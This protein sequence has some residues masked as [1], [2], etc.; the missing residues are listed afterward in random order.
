MTLTVVLGLVL[1]LGVVLIVSSFAWPATGGARARSRSAGGFLRQRLARAGLPSVSL[2]AVG[3]VSVV[4]GLAIAALS[5]ALV[6]VM[7]ISL[8][9]G[10]GALALPLAMIQWRVRSRRRAAR[11]LWPD[12][13]DHLV[14]AVRSGLALPDSVVTL[15]HTGPA[16]TRDA[17]SEF[18][19]DY[20]ATGNFGL[21]LDA[22]KDR[23]ADPVADRILETLRMSREVG[24]SELTTVLRNLSSYLRQ[25]AAIR[26]EVE[27]RQ[28][29]VVNA[30]RLG[31]A[32]PWVI[33][34][35][36]ATRP[37]AAA[38]YNTA[39]GALLIVGGLFVTVIA[40]RLMLA[41]GRFPEERRW[42]A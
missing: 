16:P 34:V 3:V 25:E 8:I 36:L 10:A 41:L 15:A 28:S 6:P 5:F 13:V 21:S 7:A 24:G 39:G 32:A 37:E 35:L 40:Y 4:G 18:A 29:W 27:A 42:F 33:L 26:S 22:L 19:R 30:A 12:I 2:T 11:V 14:S 23:L 20:R 1:G 9:A 31:V 38:A 17:F